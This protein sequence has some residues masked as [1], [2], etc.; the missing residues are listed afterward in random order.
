MASRG[1]PAGP[2]VVLETTFPARPPGAAQ[3]FAGRAVALRLAACANLVRGVRSVYW[4][5]GR[6]VR[7]HEVVVSF[8]TTGR[9][10]GALAAWVRREHPYDVPYVSVHR[11]DVRVPGYGSW[12]RREAHA[13]SRTGPVRRRPRAVR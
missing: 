11:V 3:R 9:R 13:P 7:D 6:I 12:V 10:A 2:I 1:P 5:R 8:K 4:W